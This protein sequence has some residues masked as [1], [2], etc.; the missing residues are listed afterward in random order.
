MLETYGSGLIVVPLISFME[1]IAIAKAFSRISSYKIF[2]T[3]ELIALGAANIMS[4]FVSA[5]PVT[6]SF[7]R[8]A[9]N[10]Q[11]GVKT[12]LSGMIGFSNIGA[13]IAYYL[14]Y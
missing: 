7:S 4:S 2:P 5:Y 3:Q 6:G 13:W 8:T 14:I 9:V 10:N 12:P 1:A 11:S